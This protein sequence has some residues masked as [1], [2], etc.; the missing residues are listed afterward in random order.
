M[1]DVEADQKA[2]RLRQD[3]LESSIS[4]IGCRKFV[5]CF[6]LPLIRLHS[7]RVDQGS[8]SIKCEKQTC[9]VARHI[10]LEPFERIF[11]YKERPLHGAIMSPKPNSAPCWIEHPALV[12]ET[13]H[14]CVITFCQHSTSS[15]FWPLT[16]RG[17]SWRTDEIEVVIAAKAIEVRFRGKANM[18]RTRSDAKRGS[19]STA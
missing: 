18:T 1:A 16:F 15:I 12:W 6:A 14:L 8:I 4:E 19:R 10:R 17:G 11:G 7:R 2:L 3:E 13:D 9:L 5:G